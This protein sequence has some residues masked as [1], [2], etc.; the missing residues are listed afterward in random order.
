MPKRKQEKYRARR[1]DNGEWIEGYL[2]G[3]KIEDEVFFMQIPSIIG[4]AASAPQYIRVDGKTRE[5]VK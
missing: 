3:S 4:Q 2:F 5:L 1:L